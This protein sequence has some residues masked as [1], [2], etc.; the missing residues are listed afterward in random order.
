MAI[1]GLARVDQSSKILQGTI[2]LNELKKLNL[3][4]GVNHQAQEDT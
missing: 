4:A 1:A 3:L 2:V